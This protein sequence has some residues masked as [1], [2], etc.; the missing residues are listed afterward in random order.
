MTL[1]KQHNFRRAIGFR[2][3]FNFENEQIVD[4]VFTLIQFPGAYPAKVNNSCF[5][6]LFFVQKVDLT[7]ENL[8][9]Q[10]RIT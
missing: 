2:E 9:V 1:N 7:D 10:S 8:E 3:L 4:G 6:Y 5:D